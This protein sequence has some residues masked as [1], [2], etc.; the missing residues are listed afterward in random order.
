ME[1]DECKKKFL[2]YQNNVS[3]RVMADV[4]DNCNNIDAVMKHKAEVFKD[5]SR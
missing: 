1:L 2:E 3:A 4:R 5:L